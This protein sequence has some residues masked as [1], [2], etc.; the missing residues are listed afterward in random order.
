M[1]FDINVCNTFLFTISASIML[2]KCH[3]VLMET[4]YIFDTIINLLRFGRHEQSELV[5]KDSTCWLVTQY[6]YYLLLLF[7]VKYWLLLASHT[8]HPVLYISNFFWIDEYESPIISS[9]SYL[10]SVRDLTFPKCKFIKWNLLYFPQIIVRFSSLE[11][12]L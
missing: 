4:M 5:V 10:N 7:Y 11:S 8:T 12:L 3:P 9:F 6:Y 2:N 1:I